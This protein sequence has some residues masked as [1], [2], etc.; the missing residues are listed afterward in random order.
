MAD[1]PT[2]ARVV[3]IGGGVM[4]AS[5]LYNL[6]LEGWNDCVMIEKAELTSGSTWHAAGLVGQL[7]SKRNLTQMLQYSA[8]LYDQLEA[9]TLF[10]RRGSSNTHRAKDI[11]G[12][13]TK[14]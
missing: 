11:I 2:H 13:S 8:E 14:I 9:E 10:Y 5:L 6:A 3:I 12:S 1:I 4:G 7:R